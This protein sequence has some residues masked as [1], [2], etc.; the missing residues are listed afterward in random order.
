MKKAYLF[1][2]MIAVLGMFHSV[3]AQQANAQASSMKF[4]KAKH[5]FGTIPQGTPVTTEF[6][7][8]N[9]GKTPVVISEVKTS[10]GCTTPFYTKDPV[11]PGQSGVIKASYNAAKSGDFN[12]SITVKTNAGDTVLFIKGS[13]VA[14]DQPAPN[15]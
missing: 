2:L 10:C 5:D 9:T 6:S 13:V 7:F 14:K 4:E 1:T 8:K 11:P 15:K 12:K 3:Q